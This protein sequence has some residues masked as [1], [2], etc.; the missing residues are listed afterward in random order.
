MTKLRATTALAADIARIDRQR[1]NEAV[2]AEFYPCAPPTVAGRARSF[3][4][5]DLIAL[6]I[7]GRLNDEG[8]IPRH[9]GQVACRLLNFMNE[10][11]ADLDHALYVV[12]EGRPAAWVR[13]ERFDLAAT[14]M[15]G[16][17]ITSVR[18]WYLRPIRDRIIARLEAEDESRVLGPVGDGD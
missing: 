10:V 2:A 4:V 18:D 1:F 6:Y 15:S 17:E 13:R 9:A 14:H 7:Y 5:N 11:G 16:G 12:C 8:V 3:G